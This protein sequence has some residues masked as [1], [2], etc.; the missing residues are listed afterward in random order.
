MARDTTR[1]IGVWLAFTSAVGYCFANVATRFSVGEITVWGV[2]ITRGAVGVAGMLLMARLFHK[3]LGGSHFWLLQLIGI[4]GF[5]S[6]ACT[7]TAIMSIPL[8]QALVL[9]Y[10]Y[11]ALT[12]P[13]DYLINGGRVRARDGL[14]VLLAFGGCLLL[15]WPD[16]AVGLT[17]EKGHLIG[18]GGALL[19]GLAYV[20]IRRLGDD[21]SG[22]Q[23]LFAYSLWALIGVGLGAPL[24]GLDTG[25]HSL[26]AWSIGGGLAVMS[27]ICLLTGYLALRWLAPY[28]VGVIGTLEVFGGA[29][30]S[31]L[32]FN[33]PIT[34]RALLGGAVILYVALR[35]RAS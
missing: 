20:L 27:S 7:V 22:L 21:N 3:A 12:V 14:M 11:P 9:L 2:L 28:K 17:L 31:W 5:L 8:Y 19:Y 35:L 33:D 18:V 29:L 16:R 6:T 30:A 34:G 23:P 10:L 32:I 25:L 15:V 24:L 26:R 1:D 4:S 13:L